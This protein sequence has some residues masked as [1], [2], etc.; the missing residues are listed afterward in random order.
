MMGKLTRA[1]KLITRGLRRK[2]LSM[3]HPNLTLEYGVVVAGRFRLNGTGPVYI[4]AG[5]RLVN[6]RLH[7]DGKLDI[8]RNCFLNGA[9]V[10]CMQAVTI[11][12]D[13]IISDAYLTDTDF[14]NVQPEL[15]H[16]PPSPKTMRPIVIERNVW[17]G[18]RGVVL[19]G[20][21]IG[22]DSVVGSNAVVRGSISPRSL[23]IGNPAQ[24]VKV[25]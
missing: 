25:L 5:S 3:R 9:C 21:H 16:A 8:G 13:C 12:D 19:K 20:S 17:I 24:V 18:D 14:H 15:R 23:C 4:G 22:A 7:A 11:K 1:L 10:V 6:V 2:Y